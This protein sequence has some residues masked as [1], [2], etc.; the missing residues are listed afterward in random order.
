VKL[1]VTKRTIARALALLLV[2]IV[3]LAQ[4]G[5]RSWDNL[6]QLRVGERIR[7]VD[8]QM[9][10]HEGTFVGYA[11][12]AMS[13]QVGTEDRGIRRESVVRVV[14]LDR[15]TNRK[16]ALVGAVAGAGGGAA[17]GAAMSPLV[18]DTGKV[19]PGLALLVAA[20]GAAGGALIGAALGSP[21]TI[22]KR[23][24]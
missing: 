15:T 18:T 24:E 17:A 14:S 19:V 2:P 22:Y 5:D 11:P 12:D 4:T 3:A 16:N 9:T 23:A 13:L 7:V 10:T 20:V 21:R 8:A 6:M 1:Q